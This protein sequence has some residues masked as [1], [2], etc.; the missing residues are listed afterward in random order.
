MLLLITTMICK[1]KDKNLSV[2]Q[3]LGRIQ[4]YLSNMINNYKAQEKNG[5]FAQVIK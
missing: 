1:D 5:E 3:F 4:P 2:K